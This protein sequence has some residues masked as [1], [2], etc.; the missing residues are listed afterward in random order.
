MWFMAFFKAL[1]WVCRHI[2]W[3]FLVFLFWLGGLVKRFSDVK[4]WRE[5]WDALDENG[6]LA[7]LLD[8]LGRHWLMVAIVLVGLILARH[9][10]TQ[11]LSRMN[12][13]KGRKHRAGKPL[14][15]KRR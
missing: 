7:C 10:Y 15:R 4:D 14:K 8:S 9:I 12:G 5:F 6:I 13:S 11:E 1:G 2:W 3:C